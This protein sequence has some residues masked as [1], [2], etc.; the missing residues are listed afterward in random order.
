MKTKVGKDLQGGEAL[1]LT[2][3]KFH[4]NLLSSI[5]EEN[6]MDKSFLRVIQVCM[7]WRGFHP[8]RQSL[9]Q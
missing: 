1:V 5:S 6:Y 7:T 4:F 2:W 9:M 3:G 8:T